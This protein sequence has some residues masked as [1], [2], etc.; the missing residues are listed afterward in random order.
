MKADYYRWTLSGKSHIEGFI[1]YVNE[2]CDLDEKTFK[3][4]CDK[5]SRTEKPE[6]QKYFRERAVPLYNKETQSF[7]PRKKRPDNEQDLISVKLSDLRF[8]RGIAYYQNAFMKN[9]L[10]IEV[11]RAITSGIQDSF[12][13]FFTTETTF[14]FYPEEDF[15]KA[16]NL[17]RDHE[18]QIVHDIEKKTIQELLAEYEEE[19]R[20]VSFTECLIALE[21]CNVENNT[22]RCHLDSENYVNKGSYFGSEYKYSHE[23]FVNRIVREAISE[24]IPK[25]V[26]YKSIQTTNDD[27]IRML[28]KKREEICV[29][30]DELAITVPTCSISNYERGN[31]LLMRINYN[32]SLLSAEAINLIDCHVAQRDIFELT[33][34]DIRTIDSAIKT[35]AEIRSDYSFETEYFN[36]I[37]RKISRTIIDTKEQP[38]QLKCIA[39]DTLKTSRIVPHC[40]KDS[41]FIILFNEHLAHYSDTSILNSSRAMLVAYP[42]KIIH[43]IDSQDYATYYYSIKPGNERVAA[44]F[45]HSYFSNLSLN[46]R[47][48]SLQ[49]ESSTL[50]P[51][52]GID[53]YSK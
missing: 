43:F 11:D 44:F 4:L 47:R 25:C 34:M 42:G 27:L 12:S 18:R 39:H 53:Y 1:K 51:L 22:I 9:K 14:A 32:N 17:I 8:L 29:Y 38:W 21:K 36:A 37:N 40:Y 31:I 45:I 30:P 41:L 7:V 3:M 28:S 2:H 35:L 6:I 24:N 10:S 13:L 15:Q 33:G 48:E 5:V 46:N 20:A 19:Y 50:F 23:S 52:F 16:I 26:V 49:Y